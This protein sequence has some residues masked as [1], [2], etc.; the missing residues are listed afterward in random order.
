MK[1][2]P[3]PLT[4]LALIM[5][6]V[7]ISLPIQIM[8]LY[9]HPPSEFLLAIHKMPIT[10]TLVIGTSLLSA[11]LAWRASSLLK[12]ALPLNILMVGWNNWL[13][14]RSSLNEFPSGIAIASFI[15]FLGVHSLCLHPQALR[16]LK[17]PTLRWWLTPR[18][19]NVRVPIFIQ[20]W[21]GETIKAYTLDIS[22]DGLF[23]PFG[24][25]ELNQHPKSFKPLL[26]IGRRVDLNI[27][28]NPLNTIH[29][30]AEIVRSSMTAEGIYPAGVGFRILRYHG[31]AKDEL[32]KLLAA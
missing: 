18:R 3:E 26:E 16:V 31:Q 17:D 14:E 10:N 2:R 24:L 20:T 25:R 5:V 13:V 12:F 8:V 27:V 22:D 7:A 11:L 19:K 29:C 23:V 9:G 15:A 28:L 21:M 4:G 30:E 32:K 6:A 1:I